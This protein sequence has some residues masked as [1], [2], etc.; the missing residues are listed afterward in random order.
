MAIRDTRRQSGRHVRFEEL[1]SGIG[2]HGEFAFRH[3]NQLFLLGM[4]A[5]LCRDQSRPQGN[6]MNAKF[7]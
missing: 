6:K 2:G 3:A 4:P 1:L 5:T 7:G